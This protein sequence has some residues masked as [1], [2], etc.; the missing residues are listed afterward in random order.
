MNG[1]HG[2]GEPG[3]TVKVHVHGVVIRD[4]GVDRSTETGQHILED[5][6]VEEEQKHNNIRFGRPWSGWVGTNVVDNQRNSEIEYIIVYFTT[7]QWFS[8]ETG[9]TY[10]IYFKGKGE[11]GASIEVVFDSVVLRTTIDGTGNWEVFQQPMSQQGTPEV[12][13]SKLNNGVRIIQT[14]NGIRK[15][16]YYLGNEALGLTGEMWYELP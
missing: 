1:Y 8:G 9:K 2:R 11:P 13:K 16:R 5:N 3:A 12:G 4:V 7:G 10:H 14:K 15:E 6:Q